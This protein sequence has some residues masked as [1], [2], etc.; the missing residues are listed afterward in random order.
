VWSDASNGA[1]EIYARR[2]NGTAWQQLSGSGSGGGISNSSGP[3]LDPAAA[4]HDGLLCIAWSEPL[5]NSAEIVARC[6]RLDR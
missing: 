2:W 6:L 5:L 3:S 1:A 4:I